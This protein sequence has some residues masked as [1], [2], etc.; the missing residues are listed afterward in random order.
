M[1]RHAG[2]ICIKIHLIKMIHF[3]N[4]L[5]KSDLLIL[6]LRL[7]NFVKIFFAYSFFTAKFIILIIERFFCMIKKAFSFK[8]LLYFLTIF[9]SVFK[10]FI[11]SF[12]Y[13]FI[14][15]FN[16]RNFY[17]LNFLFN[18]SILNK[19]FYKVDWLFF[20]TLCK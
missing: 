4:D 15:I 16:F 10:G 13:L 5:E 18:L 19:F 17:S 11:Y 12:N 8:K 9:V 2:F 1:Y 6:Y 14:F 7:K 3:G 20:W